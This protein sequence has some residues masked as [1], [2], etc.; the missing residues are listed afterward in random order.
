[1]NPT[2]Q[3]KKEK[4]LCRKCGNE[5][6]S[7]LCRSLVSGKWIGPILCPMCN[8]SGSNRQDIEAREVEKRIW[9][10]SADP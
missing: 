4:R 10:A 8:E 1:M 2:L 9:Y 6:L 7:L 3:T 5:F